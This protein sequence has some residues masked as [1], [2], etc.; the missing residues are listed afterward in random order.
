MQHGTTL[1]C[2]Q[3]DTLSSCRVN[4]VLPVRPWSTPNLIVLFCLL[5]VL[6]AG[7]YLQSADVGL[8]SGLGPESDRRRTHICTMRIEAV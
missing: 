5:V 3:V 1:S 6:L 8:E 4:A 7:G 2:K